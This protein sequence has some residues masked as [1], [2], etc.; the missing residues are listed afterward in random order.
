MFLLILLLP[1]LNFILIGIFGRFLGQ[2]GTMRLTL[3]NI[4]VSFFV[5]IFFIYS[6]IVYGTVYYINLGTWICLE[7][8]IINFSF[9]LDKLSL[10]MLFIVLFISYIVHLYS[11]IYMKSDPHFIR[12]MSYIS[13]FTFFMIILVSADNF[14]VLFVGWEGVG[15]CSYLLIGFWNSRLEANKASL[16]ALIINRIGDVCLLIGMVLTFFI[17]RTLDFD[18]LYLLFPYVV[19]LKLPIFGGV[20][21]TSLLC[22]LFLIG[23]IGKSAQIGLHLWLPDAM[24]GPTPVSALIHAAT[25]VT[26]GI[27]LCIRLSF[28]IEFSTLTLNIMIFI[29]SFSSFLAGL[30]GILQC[31]IKKIIAYSTSTQLGYMLLMCGLSEYDLALYHLLNHAFFKALLF[32]A[33]GVLIHI[34]KNQDLRKMSGLRT[35][36]PFLYVVLLIGTFSSD[37]FFFFSSVESK[38]IILEFS[39]YTLTITSGA[40]SIFGLLSLFL[41]ICYN[42]SILHLCGGNIYLKTRINNI[43]LR[44]VIS[45][46]ILSILALVSNY[47]LL[48]SFWNEFFFD[49]FLNFFNIKKID[50]DMLPYYLKFMFIVLFSTVIIEVEDIRIQF[51]ITQWLNITCIVL[52]FT[53]YLLFVYQ[54]VVLQTSGVIFF[55]CCLKTLISNFVIIFCV[56][57]VIF[58]PKKLR[59]LI[60]SSKL[61]NFIR[62]FYYKIYYDWVINF[63][64]SKKFISFAYFMYKLF[65]KGILEVLGPDGFSATTW[66]LLKNYKKY[67]SGYLYNY[68]C[69]F[70]IGIFFI[71]AYIEYF[72]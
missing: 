19:G 13:L 42:S 5:A 2:K 32:L 24:E 34:Y 22:I 68:V 29:G 31:D 49:N 11:C 57:L 37:G 14:V 44:F 21:V 4:L 72:F 47:F 12:F 55:L 63:D 35:I 62:F 59:T 39:S 70:F 6:L 56:T 41:T 1:L 16:K 46:T 9:V 45:L 61:G 60:E 67:N 33:G 23:I 40:T 28:L 69:L 54:L 10:S 58:L 25:M 50:T 53:I 52:Y 65:D 38:D 27:Y 43:D 36:S 7:D 20:R 51:N 30:I 15:L 66:T 17:F 8:F 71:I 3:L 48:Q 26:A 18:V 64:I